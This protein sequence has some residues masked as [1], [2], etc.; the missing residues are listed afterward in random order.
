MLT[1]FEPKAGPIGGDGF[2]APPLTWSLIKP[3][4]SFAIL[5]VC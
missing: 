5:I 3:A 2:A 4:T 1:P